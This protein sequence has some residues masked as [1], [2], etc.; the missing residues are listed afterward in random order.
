VH[1]GLTVIY[2][3]LLWLPGTVNHS[4]ALH[5]LDQ[6][7]QAIVGNADSDEGNQGSG[8]IVISVPGSL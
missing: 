3:Y 6:Q 2:L 7:D 8:M 1:E 5:T 4:S